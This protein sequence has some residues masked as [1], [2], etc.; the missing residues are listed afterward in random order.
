MAALHDPMTEQEYTKPLENFGQEVV[1]GKW[2]EVEVLEKGR[3]ALQQVNAE[4]G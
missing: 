3:K 4:M 2:Q 1:P